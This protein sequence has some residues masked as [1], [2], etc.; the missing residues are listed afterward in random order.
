MTQ[1]KSLVFSALLIG[2]AGNAMAK[3][4]SEAVAKQ[5]AESFMSSKMEQ[6][7]VVAL[8]KISLSPVNGEQ[9]NLFFVFGHSS[10]N[11]FVIVAADD[12]VKPILAYSTDNSFPSENMSPQ[13]QYWLNNYNLQINFVQEQD[14]SA[15]ADISAQWQ[16]YLGTAT[17]NGAAA[18]PTNVVAPLVATTWDQGNYYNELCPTSGSQTTP[19]GCV[20]TAMAQI[21]KYW[22][23]PTTG[24]GSYS[25]NHNQF[26]QQSADFG[27]TTYEWAVMP[28]S[29]NSTSSAPA[30]DAVSTLMYHC[31]VAVKMNYGLQG[32][33]AQVIGWGSYPSALKAFKTNFG[34]KQT[35]SGV[36]REDYTDTQWINLLKNEMDEAR[37]VLYAG[38]DLSFNAGHA[39]VFDGYDENDLF[40]VNWGWSGYYNGYFSVDDL[41]PSGTGTGGGSGYYNDDQHAIINIEP[42]NPNT[43]TDS[44]A[45]VT[46]ITLSISTPTIE[47]GDGFTVT[48]SFGNEGTLDYLNGY[49]Q[50][51][52]YNAET[53]EELSYFG[54]LYN[55]N[56]LV[57]QDTTLTFTT[58]GFGS[59]EPGAYYVRIQYRDMNENWINLYDGSGAENKVDL[60]ILPKPNSLN[61]LDEANAIILYPNPASNYVQLDMSAIKGLV[62][63]IKCFD[64]QG[65]LVDVPVQLNQQ[66][67]ANVPVS[68]L[69]NGVYFLQINTN[70]GRLHKKFVVKH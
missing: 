8:E 64:I 3:P 6:R 37:P 2:I 63:D 1:T 42:N 28:N 34:Y 52:M 18:K 14:I 16:K 68:H 69:A 31:G 57:N 5:V 38:Y 67:K 35:T 48:A 15:S 70:E 11:G 49:I 9:E 45:L 44:V 30:V 58:N 51:R 12:A 62:K 26:G 43:I 39:F 36:W 56:I 21:M 17:D 23:A 59:L 25:Y 47:Q 54:R 19:T 65:K 27:A 41:A 53:D 13:V 33:G 50:A 61:E 22:N 7:N 40:H 46:N 66:N 24:T 29:L 55:Q 4:V 20:A 32:S 60:T 10:N